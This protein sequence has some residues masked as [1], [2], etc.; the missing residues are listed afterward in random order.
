MIVA[1]FVFVN[2]LN[3]DVFFQWADLLHQLSDDE[4]RREM[5]GFFRSF[6]NGVGY[7]LYAYNIAM[8]RY[9]YINGST[10]YYTHASKR[11]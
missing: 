11:K 4:A 6:D 5:R 1:A 3:P 10:H 7:G 2:G 8:N 9:Q